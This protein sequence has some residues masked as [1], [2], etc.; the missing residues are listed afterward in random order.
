MRKKLIEKFLRSY[1][2]FHRQIDASCDCTP[3]KRQFNRAQIELLYSLHK[4]GSLTVGEIAKG[5]AVTSSAATQLVEG[6]EQHGLITRSEDPGDRRVVRISLS[7]KG[8]Q[9]Y[10]TFHTK[11]I[12]LVDQIM[13]EVSVDELQ[14]LIRIQ[15]KIQ[16]NMEG[17]AK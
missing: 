2:H 13:T 6:M 1:F 7:P 16:S 14:T 5:C 3:E 12:A 9:A 10:K 4:H 11:H 15:D 17:K 8:Q